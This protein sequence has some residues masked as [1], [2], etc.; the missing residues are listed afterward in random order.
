MPDIITSWIKPHKRS[1]NGSVQEQIC[2]EGISHC[3]IQE[4]QGYICEEVHHPR[5]DPCLNSINR[6]KVCQF[7]IN[8]NNESSTAVYS[9]NEQCICIC[10]WWQ[11][12]IVNHWFRLSI[13][14]HN[15]TFCMCHTTHILGCDVDF[16]MPYMYN[17]T[18]IRNFTVYER[19]I[20][21]TL[22]WNCPY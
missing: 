15:R 21:V 14:W 8:P 3:S 16:K 10:T 11:H 20:P 5:K 2:L 4:G 9:V 1:G 13:S 18:I 12:V 19:I 6:F 7:M 22:A 17:L